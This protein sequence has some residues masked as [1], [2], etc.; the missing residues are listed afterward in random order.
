[1][2]RGTMAVSFSS[3]AHKYR[4]LA[5]LRHQVRSQHSNVPCDTRAPVPGELATVKLKMVARGAYGD[6]R[7]QLATETINLTSKAHTH[8]QLISLVSSPQAHSTLDVA[9]SLV[10]LSY[11]APYQRSSQ[12]Y[13]CQRD[14]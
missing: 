5:F 8:L 3:N 6:I 12:K 10:G 1:M 11:P 4:Q 13:M 14:M 9:R 2:G 7:L